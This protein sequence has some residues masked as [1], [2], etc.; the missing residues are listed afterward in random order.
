M[1][2]RISECPVAVSPECSDL[3]LLEV[4]TRDQGCAVVVVDLQSR[5]VYANQA[6]ARW[7]RMS[8]RG[9]LGRCVH[10]LQASAC[11]DGLRPCFERA[12]AGQAQSFQRL[13]QTPDGQPVWHTF[14]LEP[15]RGA[16]GQVMGV[17]SSALPVHELQD[18]A[19][20]LRTANQKLSTQMEN[21]PLA[22]VEM[23]PDLALVHCSSRATRWFGWQPELLRGRPVLGLPGLPAGRSPL[24]EALQRLQSGQELQNRAE[25]THWHPDGSLFHGVWFNSVLTNARGEVLSILAQIEDVTERVR[26]TEQLWH[27]AR[28]DSLTGLINRRAL[29]G[30]MDSALEAV[31]QRGG[32]LVL[33]F[34]DLDG[35][36]SVNDRHGHSAG[37]DVLRLVAR[38]LRAAVR[39][40]DTVARLGGDE[41]VVLL[42]E[43]VTESVMQ[44]IVGRILLAFEDPFQLPQG[45]V[46]LGVSVG[47][48]VH[49]SAEGSVD[50]LVNRAD[51]AMYQA[52]RAGKGGVC[53]AA[54]AGG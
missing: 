39:H 3:G 40:S 14:S 19:E 9:L 17:V 12:L 29:M 26:A 10:E 45:A 54:S 21:S 53:F 35:F 6:W 48:A 30:Q 13:L 7:F 8:P 47:V 44:Q 51:Q 50:E 1:S 2:P 36:K 42:D 38:R 41:F 27:M 52:K 4:L 22:V 16:Q 46:T 37:D 33:L 18:T 15:W 43:E 32:R 31:R 5:I 11:L 20:A 49:A 34:L 24:A 28:H 25:V 23:D